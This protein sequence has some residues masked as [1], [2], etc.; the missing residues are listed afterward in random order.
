MAHSKGDDDRDQ[1]EVD[2]FQIYDPI[3]RIINHSKEYGDLYQEYVQEIDNFISYAGIIEP[4][5]LS[6]YS[7][8]KL[9]RQSFI[10]KEL[11]LNE[12]IRSIES[13]R[14]GIRYAISNGALIVGED[15][16]DPY[17]GAFKA[18][19]GLSSEFPLSVISTPISEAALV[20]FAIGNALT[21]R[22]VFAEIMF[23]DFIT[24]AFDQIVSN[25]SKFFHVYNLTQGLPL[26]IRVPNGG[27]RGYGPT[28]SQSLEKHLLGLD[29]IL[30]ISNT[31]LLGFKDI[32]T[33]IFNLKCPTIII[34][35]KIGYSRILY[36]NPDK[37]IMLQENYP[38][39]NIRLITSIH[40]VDITII[41][42][43]E[44]A[45]DV[46]DSLIKLENEIHKKVQLLCL[47]QLHPIRL[48]G[49]ISKSLGNLVI[50]VE[51]GSK[52][53]GIGGEI[54]ALLAEN[55][56]SPKIFRR[57]AAE[58]YPIASNMTLEEKLLP[59]FAKISALIK[60]E[61]LNGRI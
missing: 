49:I 28:H 32:F 34:E 27:H 14:I 45:R 18:T 30:V 54:A 13:L 46:A 1:N 43:G 37:L 8:D 20:G 11:P 2:F 19:K 7:G 12:K 47:L 56:K 23:G 51:E 52:E 21:G 57:I 50:V 38:L 10:E 36:Q 17:G 3:S 6:E 15:I 41:S 24:Y 35:N 39:G 53:F 44:I 31:S 22:N 25:A 29:N 5:L 42:Y 4:L 60:E 48:E 33:E 40:E 55:Q 9:P 61:I 58:P 16:A 26:I 59:N